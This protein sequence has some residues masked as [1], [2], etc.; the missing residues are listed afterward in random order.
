MD[1]GS[2]KSSIQ[3]LR[4]IRFAIEKRCESIGKM[5]PASLIMYATRHRRDTSYASAQRKP[6]PRYAH[7]VYYDGNKVQHKYVRKNNLDDTILLAGNYRKFLGWMKEIRS[8]NRRIVELLEK[9]KELQTQPIPQDILKKKGG[10]I[11]RAKR[12]K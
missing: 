6:Y 4:S 1:I 10:K 9:I 5:I 11:E 7:L 12:K 8:L 3:K 2:L